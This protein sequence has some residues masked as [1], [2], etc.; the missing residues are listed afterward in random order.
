MT[1]LGQIKYQSKEETQAENLR[2]MFL[3][4]AKD[5]RVILIKLADRLHNMRTMQYQTPEKQIEKSRETMEIY[6]PIAQRLGISK[7]KVELDDLSLK[8]LQPEVYRDLERQLKLSK[9]ARESFVKDTVEEVRKHVES[10]GISYFSCCVHSIDAIHLDVL[11]GRRFSN[12]IT[13]VHQ[14]TARFHFVFKL[15]Q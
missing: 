15:F 8:Y 1:K 4:M 12:T 14:D 6:S 9:E 11:A 5:I 7:I 13:I 2:K 3:A 10:F